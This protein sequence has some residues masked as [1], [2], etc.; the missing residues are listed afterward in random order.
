MA[1]TTI[2]YVNLVPGA[3]MLATLWSTPCRRRRCSSACCARATGSASR[4][5]AVG[6]A[7]L[8]TV[9]E[10]G[11]IDDWFGSPFI[12]QLS[13]VAA[14]ALGVFLIVRAHPQ[15]DPLVNFR[16]LARRNFGFGTLG[17]FLLGFALYGSA[18][19]LP[20]YLVARLKGSMPSRSAR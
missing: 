9:L 10:E 17:N 5:M 12:V 20:Q 2:F 8:Q 6:L 3:L 13:L 1:G 7:T 19:L 15:A 4:L 16:L 11:N 18:Y 14:V